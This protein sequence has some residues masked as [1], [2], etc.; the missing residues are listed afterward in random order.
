MIRFGMVGIG[1]IARDYA[2]LITEGKAGN[3]TITALSSR[4]ETHMKQLQ[5]E[6]GLRDATPFTDYCAMLDSGAIDAVIICT[7]H[8]LHPSM[9]KAAVDRGIHALIEKPIGVFPDEVEDL[10]RTLR[11]NPGVKSGVLYCRRAGS[12]FQKLH[13]LAESGF[14][15]QLKHASWIITNLYRPQAY[16]SAQ[17]WKGTYAGEG[18]GL[19]LTQ[20][21]HQ[22]DLLLWML[23][24]PESVH[25]FCGFGVERDIEVENDAVLHLR[26]PGNL[27]A[28]FIASSREFPGSN[29]LEISGS[30]GQAVLEDDREL[31]LRA[32]SQ[33]ERAF[34]RTTDEMFGRIPFTEKTLSFGDTDNAAQQAAI[35]A[36]FVSAVERDGRVLCSV[37]DALLS[38]RTINAAY[39][40]AWTGETVSLD[41]DSAE[42]RKALESRFC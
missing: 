12:A 31:T 22:L 36:N 24:A 2:R 9:A 15:G 13:E 19:L 16:H 18:G 8:S 21:S 37:E 25:A 10:L 33:D 20:A 41:F 40:S 14:F 42:Y 17:T 30:A 23:G 7:P 29:R 32:L 26:Y 38:L 6:F 28:Q 11:A 4:S 3:C 5:E 1:V 35:I 27:T 39:L 34:S